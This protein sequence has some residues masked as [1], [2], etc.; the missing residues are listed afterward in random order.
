MSI[1]RSSSV[2][3][4]LRT[5]KGYP[6]SSLFG[7]ASG[8][9]RLL[10]SWFRLLL[11]CGAVLLLGAGCVRSPKTPTPPPPGGIYRSD[12]GGVT[13]AQKV[14]LQDGRTRLSGERAIPNLAGLSVRQVVVPPAVPNAVYVV[15]AEGVFRTT[16]AGEVWERLPLR[17]R[18]PLSLSVHPSNPDILLL[19]GAS[20][21]QGRGKILKSLTGGRSWA[22]VFTA[23]AG[24]EEVGAIVRRRRD[25]QTLVTVVAHDPTAPH[26]SL[27]GTNTGTL[28]ASADGGVRWMTRNFFRQGITGLKF[29]PRVAGRVL[30][31]LADGQLIRSENHGAT[32]ERARIARDAGELLGIGKKPEAVHT[33]LFEVQRSDGTEP[34]LVGTEAGLYRSTDGGTSWAALPLPPTGSVDTPVTSLAQGADGT[35]W[36]VSGFVLFSSTDRGATWRAS[37]TGLRENIR[38]V[39]TD[40]VNPKRLYM[41]FAP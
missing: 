41:F 36:A 23:P 34:I 40:P 5:R 1:Q 7:Y 28:L 30:I 24:A 37:D 25:V 33:V 38:F 3:I 19:S 29:S 35:L 2:E 10:P 9:E 26:F 32:V 13:F 22:D 14:L 11:L 20:T 8:V 17:V 6:V 39:A 12:D 18:E 16:T 31:R 15:A 21:F 27:A 4:S